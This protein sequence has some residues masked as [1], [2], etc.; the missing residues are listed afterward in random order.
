MNKFSGPTQKKASHDP[1]PLSL[2]FFGV[3]QNREERRVVD[4]V[5]RY[6]GLISGN[7]M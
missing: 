4:S 5:G 1:D 3:A 6:T 7:N 2:L